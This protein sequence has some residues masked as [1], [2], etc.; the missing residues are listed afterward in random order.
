[1]LDPSDADRKLAESPT[2]FLQG[3]WEY[4]TIPK[5]HNNR[6]LVLCFDG[7]GDK[8]DA[9]VRKPP[10][11]IMLS[12]HH[13]PHFRV[14]IE[15]ERRAVHIPAKEGQQARTDGLLSGTSIGTPVWHD[16]DILRRKAGIGTYVAKHGPGFFT[17]VVKKMSKVLDEAVAWNLA[18]HTQ[19]SYTIAKCFI[20]I[21]TGP[22]VSWLR[23]LDAT[24]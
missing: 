18:S 10:I 3:Q 13:H 15:L 20:L 11:N 14:M 5:K 4:E 17:P 1:M 24:L 23:I 12:Y 9:D 8:F 16:T 19:C 2:P 6:T 22:F 21:F 7:T